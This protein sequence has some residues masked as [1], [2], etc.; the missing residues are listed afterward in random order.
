MRLVI[1]PRRTVILAAL[2]VLVLLGGLVYLILSTES[3]RVLQVTA[4]GERRI[5][6]YSVQTEDKRVALTFDATWGAEHT[7]NL[8]RTLAQ[9][10]VRATFFLTNIW[11]EDYP[12]QTRGIHQAGH[13]LALHSASHP[14][15]ATLGE[16]DIRSQLT[17]NIELM[18]SVCPEASPRLFRPP[19]GSYNNRLLQVAEDD[20]GLTTIQWSVDSLDWKEVTAEYVLN[21]VTTLVHPGAIIL[22]HNGSEPTAEALG[23]IIEQLEGAGYEMVTVSE[24]L[25]PRP[26]EVDHR[27]R[28][29]P[30]R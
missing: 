22:F 11:M 21:R 3:L 20:L 5:P 13:E 10:E 19:F 29:I 15:M 25:H 9:S 8:L 1:I 23:D 27:G 7:S 6:V 12:D 4:G 18:K 30:R 16:G 2:L 14:D 24:L 17:D 28:Q 26:Y